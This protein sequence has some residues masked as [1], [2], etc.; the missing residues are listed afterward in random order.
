MDN[1]KVTFE[2]LKLTERREK[3]EWYKKRVKL[4]SDFLLTMKIINLL[5]IKI[6]KL[7]L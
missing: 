1:N 4:K 7:N 5:L 3:H 2:N 6:I